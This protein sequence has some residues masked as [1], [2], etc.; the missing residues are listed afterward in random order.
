MKAIID[1]VDLDRIIIPSY[2]GKPNEEKIR[3]MRLEYDNSKRLDNVTL[4]KNFVLRD[5]YITYLIAKEN[6]LKSVDA[7]IINFKKADLR[8]INNMLE[9]NN[10]E[11]LE[12]SEEL[13]IQ[14]DAKLKEFEK[15]CR[16]QKVTNPLSKTGKYKLYLKAEGKCPVCGNKLL[17]VTNS[18]AKYRFSVDHQIP[19]SYDGNNSFDNCIAMCQRCNTIKD[20]IMPDVFKNLFQ[21]AMAEEALNNPE[22]QNLLIKKI[23]KSKII[24]CIYTIKTAIL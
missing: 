20:Q 7:I 11:P 6:S 14:N 13:L 17:M 18:P 5:G 8:I 24:Q 19:R 1:K 10:A 4:D 9:H 16:C 21:S 23:L 15:N 12:L 22:F 3:K 2:M